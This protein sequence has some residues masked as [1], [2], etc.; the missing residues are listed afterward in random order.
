M[1]SNR[2]V[3]VINYL[4]DLLIMSKTKTQN[5]LDLDLT[6]NLLTSLGFMINWDKVCPPCQDITF[7]GI[8]VNSLNRTLS[9][10]P[11]KLTKLKDL[12]HSWQLKK[13]CSKKELL[14][15]LGRLNWAC[16]VVR[17]GRTFLRRLIDLAKKLKQNNQN[18]TQLTSGVNRLARLLSTR[19]NNNIPAITY[20]QKKNFVLVVL[21]LA[22]IMWH[23]R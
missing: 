4:D 19:N 22:C 16:R 5:W 14:S 21:R 18:R 15:L 17:G 20:L 12:I 8:Q 1:L 9:L 11:P 13:R 2:G 6:I 3:S 10:P 7:L 23:N